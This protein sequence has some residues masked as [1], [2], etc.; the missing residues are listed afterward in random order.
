MAAVPAAAPASAT[1]PRAAGSALVSGPAGGAAALRAGKLARNEKLKSESG[2]LRGTLKQELNDLSTSGFGKNSTDLLKFHGIYQEQNRDAD[3]KAPSNPAILMLRARISGGRLTPQQYLMYDRLARD[4]G[5]GSIRLTTR[6]TIQFHW[7]AK[8]DLKAVFRGLHDVLQG[9]HGACGD[10]V[11]NVTCVPNPFNDPFLDKVE[12]AARNIS[13]HFKSVSNAYNEIWLDGQQVNPEE[14]RE[15]IYGDR[16]LPRKF[17]IGLTCEGNNAIDVFTN[18]LALAATKGDSGDVSGWHVYVG[19]GHGRSHN[20]PDTWAAQAQHLGWVPAGK[21][22]DVAEAVVKVQRDAGDRANRKHARLKYT[23]DDNGLDWFRGQV[24]EYSGVKLEPPGARPL[25]EWKVPGYL[26]WHNQPDGK[27]ALGLH[28]LSGRI[29]DK[30]GQYLRSAIA[31]AVKKYSLDVELLPDQDI[32][33]K[34]I[35]PAAKDDI[36]Q[37]FTKHRVD[38]RPP[39][40]VYERA[41]ACVAFPTCSLAIT[42]S[43]RY[44][45]GILKSMGGLLKKHGFGSEAPVFRITGCPNGCGRPYTAELALVGQE[46]GKDP[47]GGSYQV[48]VGGAANGTRLAELLVEKWP[49]TKMV[50][51]FDSLFAAWKKNRQSGET[52]GDFTHRI[53]RPA[54]NEMLSA[55]LPAGQRLDA[56]SRRCGVTPGTEKD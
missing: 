11:R 51:L 38:I 22:M 19:G 9:A 14:E 25:P 36:T 45:P 23:V 17:K 52:F 10:I 44:L 35:P 54:L 31:E 42:E 15:P 6:Q 53:P 30:Q 46:P 40:K 50:P 49:A 47:S 43:E 1:V 29:I 24:E 41:M 28:T 26:G 18:D 27:L 33:L 3:P 34:G 48:Y 16:Y 12:K 32:M 39:A 20:A 2:Y 8:G 7:L 56:I 5:H 37:L 55:V 13:E 4:Y 21:M